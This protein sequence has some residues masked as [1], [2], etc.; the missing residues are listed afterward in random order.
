MQEIYR[1][2]TACMAAYLRG[3][4]LA[5]TLSDE[6]WKA[7]YA[8]AKRQ[9]LSGALFVSL[10]RTAMP[11]AMFARLQRDAYLTLA[12]YE[13]QQQAIGDIRAAL[14][15]AGVTHAFFK[16][17][18]V[19]G[20]YRD[21]TMRSMGDIDAV[22]RERDRAASHEALLQAGFTVKTRNGE[23][24]VYTRDGVLFEL[25]TVVRRYNARIQY[26]EDYETLWQDTA[27]ENRFTVAL[28][29][30]AQAAFVIAHLASHFSGGGCGIRQLMDVAACF[31]HAPSSAA[32]EAVISRL[33]PLGIDGFARR[34]L[35]LCRVWFGCDVPDELCTPLDD[36]CEQFLL[37]RL[38]DDGT[39]G[40]D[41]RVMLAQ[42][43]RDTRRKQAGGASGGVWR[44]IFPP[45]RELRRRYGYA[46]H[47][48]L[49]PVAY[50]H[51][52]VDGATK[53][54]RIHQKRVAFA[55]E[56]ADT[57]AYEAEMFEKI[58]L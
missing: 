18:V 35:W 40:T 5:P 28:R 45:A 25:H 13:D 14:D 57:L 7:L 46:K 50:G 16:G 27:Q 32:W 29:D 36:A 26:A 52:L 37:C 51:R 31:A 11:A 2:F 30:D 24:W 9:S 1:V 4:T 53:N 19:R 10:K 42:L 38:L 41:E 15:A 33:E 56:H 3:E 48:W 44:R 22:I 17:A 49:L 54:R 21:P 20:Y 55:K 43:R 47:P 23:V 8:V 12:R 39:F 58:G 34:L 6:Q